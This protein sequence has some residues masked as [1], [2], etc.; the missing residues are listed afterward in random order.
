MA[1]VPKLCLNIVSNSSSRTSSS[2]LGDIPTFA[3]KE[4]HL[5]REKYERYRHVCSEV[6]A[7]F[8]YVGGAEAASKVEELQRHGITHV[9]NCALDTVQNMHESIGVQYLSLRM[10]DDGTVD[11]VTWFAYHVFEFVEAAWNGGGRV[12]IHC[13]SG[14]SRSCALAIAFLM[15]RDAL[16]YSEAYAA[17]RL[18]RPVC[19]PNAAFQ[20]QLLAWGDRRRATAAGKASFFYRAVYRWHSADTPVDCVAKL[21]VDRDDYSKPVPP[22]ANLLDCRGAFVIIL[23]ESHFVWVGTNCTMPLRN[24]ATQFAAWLVAYDAAPPLLGVLEQTSEWPN[25]LGVSLT[26]IP[27]RCQYDSDYLPLRPAPALN[28][29]PCNKDDPLEPIP[30]ACQKSDDPIFGLF[31]LDSASTWERIVDYDHDDL[32]SDKLLLL[33]TPQPPFYVWLG[34]ASSKA[35]ADDT[36][37]R[38]F[39]HTTHFADSSP[40][41]PLIHCVILQEGRESSNFWTDFEAGF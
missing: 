5:K 28:Q 16:T 25:P 30:T 35:A 38:D 2:E 19:E 18:G 10:V 23:P 37:L 41:P 34:S 12:L 36:S 20:S 9:V 22:S 13:V 7:K 31:E 3:L 33:K 15:Q 6:V 21:C 1:A 39:L 27:E 11:D 24:C 29:M 26:N 17:V 4:S 32:E 8:L 14:V 40:L